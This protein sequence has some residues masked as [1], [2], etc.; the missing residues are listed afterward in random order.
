MNETLKSRC[1]SLHVCYEP[2]CRFYVGRKEFTGILSGDESGD[3]VHD[4]GAID[5]LDDGLVIGEIASHQSWGS[6]RKHALGFGAFAPKA[7]AKRTK[8]G[9][10]KEMWLER[11]N[12]RF[13]CHSIR[14]YLSS[15]QIS[16][17]RSSPSRSAVSISWQFIMKPASPTTATALRS[18]NTRLAAMAPG[19][20]M[21]I[22]ANPFEMMQVLG[23]SA[24]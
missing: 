8:S 13:W 2:A 11:P 10:V 6:V 3:M 1:P 20:A 7:S 15:R 23:A 16:T 4:V 17:T 24:G 21:P 22:A 18:G 19:R 12:L 9:L 14:P 5:G